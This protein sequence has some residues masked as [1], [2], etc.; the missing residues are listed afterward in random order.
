VVC[1]SINEGLPATLVEAGAAC[2]PVVATA[3]GGVPDLVAHGVNG[4]LVPS[5]DAEALACAIETVLADRDL[6]ARL[7]GEGRRIAF[8]R[9]GAQRLV[10]ETEALYRRL[11]GQLAPRSVGT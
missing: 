7:G 8:T 3:V 5:G 10:D 4:L 9:Y 11:L 1:C 6:A 2:R